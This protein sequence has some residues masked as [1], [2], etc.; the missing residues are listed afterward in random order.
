M[1]QKFLNY[2]CNMTFSF[3]LKLLVFVASKVD[4]N[5]LKALTVPK[6]ILTFDADNKLVSKLKPI[7]LAFL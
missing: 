4:F 1:F 6:L 5:L 7:L 2:M 3:L